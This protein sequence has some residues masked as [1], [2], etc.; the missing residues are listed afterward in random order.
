M[1]F[2]SPQLPA[3]VIGRLVDELSWE[4]RK[5]RRLRNGG[6]GDENVLTAEALLLLSY[7]PREAF[8]GGVLGAAHGAD[9]VR[10]KIAAGSEDATLQMFP[11]EIKIPGTSIGVQADAAIW[12]EHSA[13]LIEA[14][15]PRAGAQF[16]KT[17]LAREF[18]ALLADPREHR[19]LLVILGSTPPVRIQSSGLVGLH[20]GVA[21]GLEEL[22]ALSGRPAGDYER[23][24]QL[25]PETVGWITWQEIRDVVAATAADFNCPNGSVS[26]TVQRL[27]GDLVNT[28]DWHCG[29]GTPKSPSPL[30]QALITPESGN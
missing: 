12:Q 16:Q 1:D 6:R 18:L 29:I 11:T 25:I 13:V 3:S 28:V 9:H 27:A 24:R 5:I 30:A 14:K 19:L 10:S 2:A 17:Q 8:L 4:G 26:N 15:G 7:L 21:T 22:C 23:L 20:D